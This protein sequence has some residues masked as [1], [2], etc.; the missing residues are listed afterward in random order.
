M[1]RIAFVLLACL[2]S[3]PAAAQTIRYDGGRAWFDER[4]QVMELVF[5]PAGVTGTV[6]TS[7]VCK[8]GRELW[9]GTV[10]LTGALLGPWEDRGSIIRGDWTGS[11]DICGRGPAGNSG[12]FEVTLAATPDNDLGVRLVLAGITGPTPYWWYYPPRGQVAVEAPKVYVPVNYGGGRAWLDGRV[13]DIRLSFADAFVWGDIVTGGVCDASTALAG[14][15]QRVSA[16][17]RGYWEER[18]SLIFGAWG[19]DNARCDGARIPDRGFVCIYRGPG[20]RG[21]EAVVVHEVDEGG[22]VQDY[23]FDRFRRQRFGLGLSPLAAATPPV[24]LRYEGKAWTHGITDGRTDVLEL[25]VQGDRVSGGV[26]VSR[27]CDATADLAGG[28]LR[29]EG[30][31]DGPWEAPGTT[32]IGW[33]GGVRAPCRGQGLPEAGTFRISM[34]L[35]PGDPVG[36]ILELRGLDGSEYAYFHPPRG[37]LDVAFFGPAD[38]F[39]S[40]AFALCGF[41]LPGGEIPDFGVCEGGACPGTVAV[42]GGSEGGWEGSL[43]TTWELTQCT[44]P[45]FEDPRGRLELTV[46]ADRRVSGLVLL[47]G[48]GFA[49]DGIVDRDGIRSDGLVTPEG[50]VTDVFPAPLGEKGDYTLGFEVQLGRDAAGGLTASG[51]LGVSLDETGAFCRG[52][53]GE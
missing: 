22:Q 17:L 33:W 16:S 30:T 20:P 10:A 35:T 25:T 48:Q 28:S 51:V 42:T 23:H 40:D 11:I 41:A 26:E 52:P 24:T 50:L 49:F 8:P 43:V 19:G 1:Q 34:G 27:V 15:S 38:R 32:M 13:Q 44:A 36:V 6:V 39:W 3:F 5:G 46:G 12:T 45:L 7:S 2:L 14:G 31:L 29:F 53:I 9:G 21:E 47:E 4:T 37:G 18:G